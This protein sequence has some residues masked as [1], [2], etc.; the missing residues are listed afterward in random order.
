MGW[1]IVHEECPG[2]LSKWSRLWDVDDIYDAFS[3][4]ELLG[5]ILTQQIYN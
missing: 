4:Q 2:D 1:A 3:R 5:L